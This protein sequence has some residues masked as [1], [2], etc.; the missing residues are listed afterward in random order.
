MNPAASA[1]GSSGLL[2]WVPG[3]GN[4]WLVTVLMALQVHS[5]GQCPEAQSETAQVSVVCIYLVF[6]A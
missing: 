1:R 6:L 4:P 5:V 2:P 3:G